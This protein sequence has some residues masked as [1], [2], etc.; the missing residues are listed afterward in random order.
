MTATL[1]H[2]VGTNDPSQ[3]PPAP[4]PGS[5]GDGPEDV[6]PRR[7]NYG[8][9]GRLTL[10]RGLG[11]LILLLAW[12]GGSA[13]GLIDPRIMAAPWQVVAAGASLAEALRRARQAAG[14]DP[15]AQA[16]VA[17]FLALGGA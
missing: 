2:T 14:D 17:S 11:V 16:T 8:P 6:R 9:G 3:Q 13:T 7:R 12:A 1:E 10:G 4:P 5:A 15:V